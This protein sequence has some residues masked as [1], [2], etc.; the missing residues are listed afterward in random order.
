M[1]YLDLVNELNDEIEEID[2]EIEYYFYYS[3]NGY[4]DVIGFGQVMLWNSE[5]DERK[6]IEEENDYEPLKPHIKMLF[7]EYVHKL[8]NLCFE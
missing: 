4:V 1:K 6:W 2:E 3:T 7:N 5:I 8:T